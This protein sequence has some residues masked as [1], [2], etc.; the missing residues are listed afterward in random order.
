MNRGWSKQ[1][2]RY[3]KVERFC[4]INAGML[5]FSRPIYG[6]QIARLAWIEFGV[7]KPGGKLWIKCFDNRPN[8][9]KETVGE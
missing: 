9:E 4:E 5:C 7:L 2:K 8:L 1:G 6:D 3:R